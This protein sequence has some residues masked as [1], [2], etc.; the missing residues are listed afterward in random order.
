MKLFFKIFLAI[1]ILFINAPVAIGQKKEIAKYI[2]LI[3]RSV[4][5]DYKG[6]FHKAGGIIPYPFI[7]PGSTYS[8][9]LWDWDSWLSNI[10]LRQILLDQGSQKDKQE[11]VAF[12]QGCIMD[13]LTFSTTEG[14]VPIVIWKKANPLD[15]LPRD[16]YKTNMHKPVLAQHAAFLTRLNGGNADWISAKYPVL[17]A[18]L[19]NYK[20]HHRHAATGLYYWQNDLAIGVDNDP[21]TFYR[22]AGSSGSIYLNCLMYKELKAMAYLSGCLKRSD[23]VTNYLNDAE[24]LK[25]AIQKNCWDEKDGFFYSVDLDLLPVKKTAENNLGI[26]LILHNGHPRDYD[27]LIQRIGVWSG[28]MSMWAGIATPEQV[29][30]MVNENYKDPKTFFS[31]YGVRSL[32]KSEKMYSLYASGNPSNWQGPIWGIA[33]YMTFKGLLKYGYQNEASN[34][35]YKTIRLLGKD[36]E[37][38]GSFHEYYNPDTGAPIM[39]SGFKSWNYLVMNMIAWVEGRDVVNEF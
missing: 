34:L 31:A 26:T 36:V 4:Y 7:T 10:A 1:S 11:A 22:P 2:A 5:S 30:R 32:S 29:K 3:K 35:A 12:E 39:N 15:S 24:D 27:C 14:Y 25:K 28:F 13:F 33:N 23:D 18:F 37:K 9:D 20:T 19:N 38:N 16:I 21:A 17:K 6:M 8:D